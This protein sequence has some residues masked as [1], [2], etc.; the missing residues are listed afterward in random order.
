MYVIQH[1]THGRY[2]ARSE[3]TA[4]GSSYTKRLEDARVFPTRESA[5]HD[6]CGNETVRAVVEV[7]TNA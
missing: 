5:E 2:V 6:R 4:T 1:N 3:A 7:L